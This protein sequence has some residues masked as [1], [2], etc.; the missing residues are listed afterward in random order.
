MLKRI[1]YITTLFVALLLVSSCI[2]EVHLESELRGEYLLA[3]S[4]HNE[5]EV[6]TR[7]TTEAGKDELNENKINRVS[8]FFYSGDMLIW[9]VPENAFTMSN[10]TGG[11]QKRLVIKVPNDKKDD[12]SNNSL[13][14]VVIA[15]GPE[16]SRMRGKTLTEL[17]EL[18]FE[19]PLLNKSQL[20]EFL[21][22]GNKELGRVNLVEQE[23]YNI[24]AVDMKRAAAKIR[25]KLKSLAVDGFEVGTPTV[26]LVNYATK[27]NLLT[28]SKLLVGAH[29]STAYTDL[30]SVSVNGNSFLTTPTPWYSY[31]NSWDD[32]GSRETYM[33]L[34]IPFTASGITIDYF[35]RISI[36]NRLGESSLERNNL[37]EITVNINELGNT[38]PELPFEVV[39]ASV[40]VKPWETVDIIHATIS[41]PNYLV[42]KE[43]Y[44]LM[45]NVTEAKIEYISNSN[46]N[47]IA[48]SLKATFTAYNSSGNPVNGSPSPANMPK[49]TFIEEGG[50]KYIKVT[51]PIPT[52]F[53]PL[54]I[55]FSVI[56]Q[57]GLV[58]D[59]ELDQYPL[60]FVTARKSTGNPYIGTETDGSGQ[61]NY[62]LFRITTVIGEKPL[63]GASVGS[64]IGDPVDPTDPLGKTMNTD[65]ANNIISP[66][67]IIAS[68][69][70]VTNP[71]K[72][73]VDD[74]TQGWWPPW[75]PPPP[76]V[77]GESAQKRCS[78]YYEDEYGP[79][80]AKGGRW[81]LPTRAELE[82]IQAL[83]RN[84][85]S[86]VK[87]LLE[88]DRY[89]SGRSYYYYNFTAGSWTN[90]NPNTTAY[91]R[92]VYDIYKY[93]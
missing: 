5:R 87:S 14:L 12:F 55:K 13:N 60:R 37:Y 22:T 70:G 49:V 34:K 30:E 25:L 28:V 48:T 81:R 65:E 93:E 7:A 64:I 33:L 91:I 2:N 77:T 67:F 75:N 45:P 59:V 19:S 57:G 16:Q 24:G 26:R 44:V 68:K 61:S 66:Q 73:D 36:N 27:T 1:I 80:R 78:K 83:Q 56:N 6:S 74:T 4:L 54:N 11:Y 39:S 53:V 76:T 10:V 43:N 82:Y 47:L 46:V 17:K 63:P 21:I 23:P 15:N 32:D 51:S 20:E 38:T 84:P 89:W 18:V 29:K 58:E 79:G 86:A 31:E 8:L 69:Y 88:G 85:N 52:N 90:G 9:E 62:N 71:R 72:F 3:L 41:K 42:V 92:C 35:Y 50:K 40:E